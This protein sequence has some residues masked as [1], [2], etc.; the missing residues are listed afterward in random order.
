VDVASGTLSQPLS[1]V[2][3]GSVS[4]VRS[5]GRDILDPTYRYDLQELSVGLGLQPTPRLSLGSGYS[6]TRVV[7]GGVAQDSHSLD[8]TASY[9]WRWR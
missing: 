8:L 3:S 4:A 5:W 1:R 6:W 9:G 7:Y 2:L